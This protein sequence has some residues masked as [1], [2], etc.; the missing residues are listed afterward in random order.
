MEVPAL[1]RDGADDGASPMDVINN[2]QRGRFEIR[3]GDQVALLR[4]H[5]SPGRI[6]L[7]H[8]EV[9]EHLAGQGIAGKL[10]AFALGYAREHGLRVVPTCSYVGAYI[11]RHPEYADLLAQG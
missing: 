6:E 1:T 10:A 9:P 4:Y 2:R 5:E 8:T 7:I 3:V 11:E